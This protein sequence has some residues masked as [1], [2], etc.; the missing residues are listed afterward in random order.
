MDGGYQY[1]LNPDYFK[2]MKHLN[3]KEYK[4]DQ[5]EILDD[6]YQIG[7]IWKENK[8]ATEFV[9]TPLLTNFLYEKSHK[10]NTES[11]L[12]LIVETNFR[13]FAYTQSS[14]HES[15]LRLFA[16]VEYKLPNMI[17][18]TLTEDSIKVAINAGI[19]KRANC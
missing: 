8:E 18:G 16:K 2:D 3:F 13:I 11:N 7:L 15:L 14:L 17:V 6:L 12:N 4:K 10:F 9:V 5:K 19:K 1:E